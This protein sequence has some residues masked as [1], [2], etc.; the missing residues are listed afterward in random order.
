MNTERRIAMAKMKLKE[1]EAEVMNPGNLK[2]E[3]LEYPEIQLKMKKLSEEKEPIIVYDNFFD[4][5]KDQTIFRC[6]DCGH[7]WI[8][9]EKKGYYGYSSYWGRSRNS[10][11]ECPHC[12]NTYSVIRPN[13]TVK[14]S[15]LFSF[16]RKYDKEKGYAIIT[17]IDFTFKH[18][19]KDYAGYDGK[20]TDF[21]N[22]NQT[23]RINNCYDS[24]LSFEHGL[25]PSSRLVNSSTDSYIL[26]SNASEFVTAKYKIF[27]GTLIEN[28]ISRSMLKEYSESYPTCDNLMSIIRKIDDDIVEKKERK[29]EA[30]AATRKKKDNSGDCLNYEAKE[31]TDEY[32]I[33]KCKKSSNSDTPLVSLIYSDLGGVKKVLSSCVCGNVFHS[34]FEGQRE[35]EITCPV[36]EAKNTRYGSIRKE[37]SAYTEQKAYVYELVESTGELLL[38]VFNI[39]RTLQYEGEEVNYNIKE[40]YRFFISEKGIKCFER[41]NEKWEKARINILDSISSRYWNHTPFTLCNTNEELIEIIKSSVFKYS[42]LLEAWGLKKSSD[43]RDLTVEE[44][45]KLSRSSYIYTWMKNKAIEQI[46]KTGL[47]RAAKDL[48]NSPDSGEVN[49][50]GRTVFEILDICKDVYVII[51]GRNSSL[52]EISLVRRIYNLDNTINAADFQRINEIGSTNMIISINE[53]FGIPFKK[54]LEYVDSC[55]NHQC[56]E[57]TEALRIWFDYLKM[58]TDMEYRLDD[59]SRKFPGSLK[60]EHDRA[61][62][63]YKVV[64]DEMNTKRFIAQAEINKAALEYSFENLFVKV[65]TN[66]NEVVQEGTDQKHCVASYVSRIRDGSTAV[67]FIRKKEQP[68]VSYYTVEVCNGEIVQVRGY[69][70]CAPKGSELIEFIRKWA[71]RKHLKIHY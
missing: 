40:A 26:S 46:L 70:N 41:Y 8:T 12:K 53:H 37:E 24:V 65:P 42:G 60:K 55:Y 27:N 48:M 34:T 44:I 3:I 51:R 31:I 21:L 5:G 54:I 32:I 35:M 43:G 28:A 68:D 17:T 59:S 52:R 64:Q 50:S 39:K 10:T 13:S 22:N 19:A 30:A 56:I 25:R 2:Q 45:G 11:E 18:S 6:G 7:I 47:I 58:A 20:N 16:V 29:A 4:A 38:R 71:E 63:S 33:E 66:P 49:S 15:E 9:D 69:C 36:C 14:T 62:F 61:Q 23:V 57:K 1:L 67:C